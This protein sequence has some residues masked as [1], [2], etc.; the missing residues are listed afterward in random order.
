MLDPDSVGSG[1]AGG[2]GGMDN[3]TGSVGGASV[4]PG[5]C[6]TYKAPGYHITRCR[7]EC[8]WTETELK[9][10]ECVIRDECCVVASV[11]GCSP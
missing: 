8:T 2:G 1:G 9:V 5:I 11:N 3:G 10:S 6:A 4:D 7:A